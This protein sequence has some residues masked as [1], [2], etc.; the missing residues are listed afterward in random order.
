MAEE[1]GPVKMKELYFQFYGKLNKFLPD[2][3]QK[4]PFHHTFKGRQSVKDR[5]E[6][7][8]IP[9]T[10]VELILANNSP[11]DF[12]YLVESGDRLAVYPHFHQL[13]LPASYRLRE[14]YSRK[15]EFVADV[16]L[17]KLAKYLRRFNF[18]TIYQ[19]DLEDDEIIKI[20]VEDERIILTR[21][22]GILM[23]KQVIYGQFIHYDDP[24][25]QLYEVF[26]RYDLDKY[27]NG[28]KSRCTDCNS[29]LVEIDKQV[30]IDRLEPKTK[31]YF[32]RFK[33]CQECD[34]IYWEGS[35]YKRME[36][37]FEKINN[38]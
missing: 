33:I 16:H 9:H 26:N 17:G 31:K 11:V 14:P 20:G 2:D 24:R 27:Y 29:R 22:H 19:N 18:D 23:H 1:A 12:S 8:G 38:Y 7:V 36:D 32:E 25:A 21:D 30:I 28:N 5:I 10:E 6:T 15:P 37:L 13:D 4:R 34:K 35:H 3:Q